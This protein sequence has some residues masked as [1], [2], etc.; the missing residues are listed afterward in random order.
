MSSLLKKEYPV[1]L[2]SMS[3]IIGSG[4]CLRNTTLFNSRRSLTHQIVLSFLGVTNI[5]EPHLLAPVG[6][7]TFIWTKRSSSFLKAARW[8][9]GI[10][11]GW[12]C[13][14]CAPG[15]RL[16]WNFRW[17]YTSRVPLKSLVKPW[18]R[19]LRSSCWSGVRWVRWSTTSSVDTLPYFAS[20]IS[21][22]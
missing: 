17:G 6:D 13:F 16:M 9:L 10:A 8:I 3:F 12:L 21:E 1:R 22:A 15:I 11:Y 18:N 19:P 5:G 20:N 14:G 4:Y 2:R 7:K